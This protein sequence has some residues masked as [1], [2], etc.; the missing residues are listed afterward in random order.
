MRRWWRFGVL[1]IAAGVVA[2][3]PV[4]PG[5]GGGPSTSVPTAPCRSVES[6]SLAGGDGA[7]AMV[8]ADGRRLVYLVAN[9]R[10][11]LLDLQ[12][13]ADVEVGTDLPDDLR[14]WGL[15]IT[16]EG[17]RAAVLSADR[18]YVIDLDTG[19]SEAL[20]WADE[21]PPFTFQ[22]GFSGD[23]SVYVTA[24]GTSEMT[25]IPSD[26]SPVRRLPFR[27]DRFHVDQV[28]GTIA[29]DTSAYRNG[30]LRTFPNAVGPFGGVNG[31]NRA[32]SQV[33]VQ[34]AAGGVLWA[35]DTGAVEPLSLP[36]IDPGS[37]SFGG[38]LTD[39]ARVFFG[40]VEVAGES[41]LVRIDRANGSIV[42][43]PPIVDG[44]TSVSD[45]GTVFT[46]TSSPYFRCT[47]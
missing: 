30:V 20:D 27:L 23:L 26:G 21:V 44:F 10:V 24:S 36:G 16:P 42:D 19:T 11:R 35:P 33:Y 34:T 25:L 29:G 41:R 46:S 47:S 15:Q 8:S 45:D 4:P 31:V 1:M 6:V 14:L 43:L 40:Y 37:D 22:R 17:D 5:D 7:G 12:T 32:G 13:G 3:C 9:R 18:A 2:G 28:G 39:D 38:I